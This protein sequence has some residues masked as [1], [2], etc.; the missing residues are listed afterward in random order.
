MLKS[1]D[2]YNTS[3][4]MKIKFPKGDNPPIGLKKAVDTFN[5]KHHYI[6]ENDILIKGH[7]GCACLIKGQEDFT[8][9]LEGKISGLNFKKRPAAELAI[10]PEV[11]WN[12][13]NGVEYKVSQLDL[14]KFVNKV[15]GI[16]I[17]REVEPIEVVL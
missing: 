9:F 4:G 1:I 13:K 5:Q 12:N 14:K 17:F 2:N 8:L 11:D 15:F 10:K 6:K 3:F 7:S 16:K